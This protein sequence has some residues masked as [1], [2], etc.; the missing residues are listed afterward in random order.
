MTEYIRLKYYFGKDLAKLLAEK[1]KPAYPDFVSRAFINQIAKTVDDQELKQ[2][3][4]SITD[5]LIAIRVGD[6]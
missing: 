2:R 5:A 4:E 1:I 3:I 6:K